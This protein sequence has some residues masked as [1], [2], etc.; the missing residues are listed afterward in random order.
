[1]STTKESISIAVITCYKQP[2]YVRA[3][4]L[5]AAL[6]QI[7]GV[8]VIVVKN[9]TTGLLRYAQVLWQV[10][11]TRLTL[12]P[13]A[14][15]LT[16][17]GYEMLLPIRLLTIG[18]PLIY[19]EFINPI[20]WAVYEHKKLS[21]RNPL[22]RLL[23]AFYRLLLN[24]VT[25]ILADT[26]SHAE[27]SATMMNIKR[28]KFLTVPVG[29]DEQTFTSNQPAISN[30]N[31]FTVFYYGNMLPLHGLSY[32]IDAAVILKDEPII[33]VL[34]GGSEETAKDMAEA[35]DL[36]A[37]I[38]YH[39]WV[40]FD[41]LPAL[42]SSASLCLAG[43]FGGTYQSQY[44]I[45]GKAFQYLAMSRPILVG[46]NKESGVFHDKQDALIVAQADSEALADAIHWGYDNRLKLDA[47]GQAGR[48]LFEEKFTNK[49]LSKILEKE[50]LRRRLLKARSSTD[51]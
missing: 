17:R 11:V 16:F 46:Q 35:A 37:N 1:V 34:V 32:V 12:H 25:V 40:D 41:K 20:E 33:F 7:D 13:D 22:A 2:N 10:I 9:R 4:T 26:D 14:Y 44:V 42:M 23:W 19:D 6:G 24:S 48:K 36:G 30:G 39:A 5:R 43:P 31:G 21:S 49:R 45:T 38:E 27:L 15:V 29:T 8:S 18:K 51:K 28:K 50:L 3:K 47:I